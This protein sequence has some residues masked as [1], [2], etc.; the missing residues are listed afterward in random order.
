ML[1]T[2]GQAVVKVVSYVPVILLVLYAAL[3]GLLGLLFGTKGR[4]Y[5]ENLNRQALETSSLLA[6]GLAISMP[7][8][9]HS[10]LGERPVADTRG[11]CPP[12]G[13]PAQA[14]PGSGSSSAERSQMP[15]ASPRSVGLPAADGRPGRSAADPRC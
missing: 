15:K 9:R 3:L 6:H 11:T 12:S 13:G 7:H 4:A 10:W 14:A 2:S 8:G 5:V 1:Y